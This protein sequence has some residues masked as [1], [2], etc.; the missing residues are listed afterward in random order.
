MAVQVGKARKRIGLAYPALYAPP[1]GDGDRFNC[2]QRGH[3][4]TLEAAP[5]HFALLLVAGLVRP[6][7]AAAA[8]ALWLAGRVAYF[9]G[10]ATGTPSARARGAFGHLGSLALLI[11]TARSACA[12]L[13]S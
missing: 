11:I 6:R 8:G 5:S 12:L 4:N 9:L 1:G 7:P 2:I 13:R 10:Y 3:Q